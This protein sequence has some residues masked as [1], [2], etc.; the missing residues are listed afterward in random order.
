MSKFYRKHYVFWKRKYILT[1]VVRHES[2][3][4]PLPL[5]P[6]LLCVIVILVLGR[7]DMSFFPVR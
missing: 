3:L 5:V 6:P 1:R 2:S 7:V 4:A